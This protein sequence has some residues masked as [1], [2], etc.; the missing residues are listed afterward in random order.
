MSP[1]LFPALFGNGQPEIL[2]KKIS[3]LGRAI[4][5]THNARKRSLVYAR[6]SADLIQA[7]A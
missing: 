7:F 6:I 3:S 2:E 1:Y 4:S 5:T